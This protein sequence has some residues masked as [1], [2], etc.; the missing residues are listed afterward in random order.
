MHPVQGPSSVFRDL[1]CLRTQ[2]LAHTKRHVQKK[3]VLSHS[4]SLAP[5]SRGGDGQTEALRSSP[6]PKGCR[7]SFNSYVG[8]YVRKK[9][10]TW[11]PINPNSDLAPPDPLQ[12]L[13]WPSSVAYHLP[14]RNQFAR[15]LHRPSPP[16]PPRPTPLDGGDWWWG[17]RSG[18]SS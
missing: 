15:G 4:S 9:Y 12:A 18:P 17:R 10:L 3:R 8:V 2:F 11:P 14:S 7:L 6:P 16:P 1:L 5:P 13:P